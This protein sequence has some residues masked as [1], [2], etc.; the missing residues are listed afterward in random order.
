MSSHR[1]FFARVL[2]IFGAAC[3]LGT[4]VLTSIVFWKRLPASETEYLAWP[5]LQGYTYEH[6]IVW[7]V[8]ML[9]GMGFWYLWNRKKRQ[10]PAVPTAA[11]QVDNG[12][13]E[14][15]RNG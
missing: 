10:H 2:A 11:V 7:T 3:V 12:A 13:F 1:R 9:L 8:L 14:V 5:D 4:E 6:L 15:K